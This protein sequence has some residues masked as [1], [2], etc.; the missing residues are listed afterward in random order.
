MVFRGFPYGKWF[1]V[2]CHMED[3][4]EALTYGNG[5]EN[6]S[7]AQVVFRN[8]PHGNSSLEVCHTESGFWEL[9]TKKMFFRG[10]P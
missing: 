4:F 6:L 1:S 2:A 7:H 3:G 8:F 5:C 9:A 10:L